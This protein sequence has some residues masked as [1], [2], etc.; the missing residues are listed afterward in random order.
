MCQ[1]LYPQGKYTDAQWV[2]GWVGC[3]AGLDILEQKKK[4]SFFC[5]QPS[6][7]ADCAILAPQMEQN[8]LLIN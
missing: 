7:Y 2:G 6:W 4:T 5:L 8:K 1:P 3:R